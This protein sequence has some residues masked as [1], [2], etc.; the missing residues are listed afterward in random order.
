MQ[1]F[2]PMGWKAMRY[3]VSVMALGVLSFLAGCGSGGGNDE[4][5]SPSAVNAPT[6]QSI[7]VTPSVPQAVAGTTVQFTA[8]GV[9]TD[10]STQDLTAQVTW[11][12]SVSAVATVSNAVGSNGLATTTSVGTA[13]VSATSD[14]V[15]GG[16]TLTVTDATLVSIEVSPAT[17]SVAN[18]TSQQFTATGVYTDNSTQDLTTQVTWAS[19]DGAVAAVRND[20]GSNGLATTIS[21]GS[22]NVSATSGSVTGDTVLTVTDATLV[23]IE[24][25]AAT[26][27][28]ANGTSQQYTATGVFT[29]NSTQDLTTQVTWAS[30]DGAVATVSNNPGSNGLATTTSAGSTTVSATSGGVAGDTV[31]TVTDATLVSIEVS[32]LTPSLANGLTRQFTATGTFTDNSTQDLTTQVTWASSDGAVATIS[33]AASSNGLATAISAG[34]TTVSA[35]SGGVASSTSLT[36]TDATLVSIE[37]SPATP[38]VANGL[39][40]QF[41]ATGLFTDNSTQDLTTQVTWASSDGAVATV[42]N[43]ASS[44]GLATTTAAGS[45]IVSAISG[46]VTGSTTLTVTDA[47]LVSIDVSPA[48]PSVANGLTQQFTAT[49]RFSDNSTQDLTTQVTWVSSDGAVATVSNAASANGFTSTTATGGTTVSATS[50]GVTGETVLTVTDATLVSIDVSPAPSLAKG[51]T[52]Q[53]TAT[54]HFTDS[55]TQDLTTQV[56]WASS[57]GA[58]ATVSNAVSANGFATTIA[59]GSTTVSATSGGVTGET[60]LTVTDATL[61]S[62]DVS[63]ATPSLANGLTQQFTATGHFTDSSTQDLTTQVTWVSSD[64]A[65]ATVS[66]AVISNGFATTIAV[67]SAT[68]SATSGGVT[69]DTVLTVTD[70]TLVSIDVSPTTPSLANGLTQ[71]FTATGHFTDGSTQDLT[72]EVIWASWDS[73]VTTVSNDPGSN[74]LATTTAAGSTTVSATS[75]GIIGDTVLTVTD[76]TLVSIDVLPATPSVVNGLTEQ[77]TATGHFT[78]SSTQDLTTQVIW[79]SS[80]GAVATV[81]NDPGSNGLATTTAAGSTTVSA[82]TGGVTG[83]ATLIV[84]STSPSLD[85]LVAALL[86]AVTGV[87]PGASLVNQVTDVQAYLA[88]PDIVSACSAM[89]A[90]K[91][92]VSAQSGKKIPAPLATQLLADADAIEAAIP[93]P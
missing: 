88:V 83:S 78:D 49:G 56:T 85:Q 93:C 69:G 68:V 18:G 46:G 41:T 64:G 6:L 21:A 65:V 89:D 90:F 73:A 53:F 75:G 13:T 2:H 82:T 43:A 86:V 48:T 77:F 72:T 47:T 20:P 60:V 91:S 1:V 30:S 29:D 52:Q 74:G 25:S 67:G 40:Q 61:V 12:S 71:Q 16:T 35:T 34:S 17:P 32:P 22:T 27:S 92:H 26:S 4:A 9:Y 38:S 50:G 31:L 24:V 36:V 79:A 28:L 63:P 58:V 8:T 14:G 5:P 81:S 42:S 57:D 33:N 10:T 37:V 15:T 59:V 39:P 76:A 3:A 54:G 66:N 44:N 23:S 7:E 45:T 51:L 11:A 19:S 84:T 80:D 87:G 70:A 62:I 55:S